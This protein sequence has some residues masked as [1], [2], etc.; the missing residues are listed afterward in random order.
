[1]VHPVKPFLPKEYLNKAVACE[2]ENTGFARYNAYLQIIVPVLVVFVKVN[3][4]FL[5]RM[6]ATVDI[7]GRMGYHECERTTSLKDGFARQ[8]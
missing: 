3:R 8:S 5:L 4:V 2:P 1:M 6:A 7:S